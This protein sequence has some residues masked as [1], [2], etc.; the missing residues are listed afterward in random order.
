MDRLL[1]AREVAAMTGLPRITVYRLAQV[2]DLPCV[3]FLK[4]GVRFPQSAVEAWIA[5]RTVTAPRT[6][7]VVADAT[8]E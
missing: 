3:R 7:V 5:E 2:G 1:N 4:R 8:T 6:T